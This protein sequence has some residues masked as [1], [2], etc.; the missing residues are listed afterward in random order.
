MDQ[1]IASESPKKKSVVKNLAA[2]PN[3]VVKNGRIPAAIKKN[4]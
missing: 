1:L 2:D 3:I 4:I